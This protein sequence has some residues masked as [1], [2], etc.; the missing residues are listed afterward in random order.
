MGRRATYM[1]RRALALI[2]IPARCHS[3]CSFNGFPPAGPEIEESEGETE[4]RVCWE[5]RPDSQ[6]IG[7]CVFIHPTSRGKNTFDVALVSEVFLKGPI[8]VMVTFAE[9]GGGTMVSPVQAKSQK[10]V[11]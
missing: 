1:E 4:G 3:F 8:T 6:L 10:C 11:A 2:F 5:Q 7:I 9:S